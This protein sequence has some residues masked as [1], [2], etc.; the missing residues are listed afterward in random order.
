MNDCVSNQAAVAR[1]TLNLTTWTISPDM[2]TAAGSADT[3]V[4]QHALHFL[5][6]GG[7]FP[8]S[9]VL[10]VSCIESVP[11]SESTSLYT[12][13]TMLSLSIIGPLFCSF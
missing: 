5:A 8:P 6:A 10:T 9:H 12:S 2:L 7:V 13:V 11:P 1:K 4:S 3:L